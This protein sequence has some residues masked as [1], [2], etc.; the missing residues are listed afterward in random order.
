MPRTPD[1]FPGER[2]E[3]S[4]LF[5]SGS[6]FPQAAGEVLYAT[7]TISGSGFFFNEE[8]NVSGPA[9]SFLKSGSHASLRQLIHLADGDGPYEGF[10]SGAVLDTGP[11]GAFPTASIWYTDATKTKKIVSQIVTYN[12]NHTIATEQWQA[13]DVDGSTVLAT[14]T[15]TI[16]YQGMFETG[17]TRTLA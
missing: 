13:Y 15:D 2:I 1:Q 12:G 8:G 14:V 3:E 5:E 11:A 17:R 4:I 16:T 10:A 7:G 6:Q 9:S